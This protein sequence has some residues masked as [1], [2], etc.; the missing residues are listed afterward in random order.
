MADWASQVR[1]ARASSQPR[2]PVRQ[3]L[4]DFDHFRGKFPICTQSSNHAS[5]VFKFPVLSRVLI[6]TEVS[7]TFDSTKNT[8]LEAKRKLPFFAFQNLIDNAACAAA[9]PAYCACLLCLLTVPLCLR[10]HATAATAGM[11]RPTLIGCRI[12]IS[13]KESRREAH[14]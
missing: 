8:I 6:R 1:L 9:V 14:R 7:C 12:C 4:T 11:P 3:S 5:V 10:D 13:S 2:W